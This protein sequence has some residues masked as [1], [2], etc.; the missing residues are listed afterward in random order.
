MVYGQS[1]YKPK[2]WGNVG[3][4]LNGFVPN[5]TDYSIE[6]FS[7]SEETPAEG[8]DYSKHLV[9]TRGNDKI[10]L[11]KGENG[12][13]H[14]NS[15]QEYRGITLYGFGETNPKAPEEK[16]DAKKDFAKFYDPTIT[17]LPGYNY[18]AD[19][20]TATSSLV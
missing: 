6:G 16:F 4:K 14:S 10:E 1:A 17:L 9:L 20:N 8:R 18:I 13:Y 7:D 5:F 3:V 11:F 12:I 2:D 19:Y 15:A